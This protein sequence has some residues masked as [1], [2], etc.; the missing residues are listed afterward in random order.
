MSIPY[1]G[2]IPLLLGA[3]LAAGVLGAP[4]AAAQQDPCDTAVSSSRCLGP[5]GIQDAPDVRPSPPLSGGHG[6]RG[7]LL[8]LG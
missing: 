7:P 1:V 8:V 4:A 6:L 5:A 2:A 3:G